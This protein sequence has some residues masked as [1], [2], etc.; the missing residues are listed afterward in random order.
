MRVGFVGF[1]YCCWGISSHDLTK[2]KL[3]ENAQFSEIDRENDSFTTFGSNCFSL[4]DGFTVN[5]PKSGGAAM[6]LDPV[7]YGILTKQEVGKNQGFQIKS[8]IC[9][10]TH[11]FTPLGLC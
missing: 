1:L 7:T 10:N 2:P 9:M 8:L 5:N 6:G 11:N 4:S 3:N